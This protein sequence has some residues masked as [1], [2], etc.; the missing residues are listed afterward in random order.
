MKISKNSSDRRKRA[1]TVRARSGQLLRSGGNYITLVLTVMLCAAAAV[2][3]YFLTAMI[4]DITLSW[5]ADAI[6]LTLLLLIFAPMALGAVRVAISIYCG[7][8]N[9]IS[10]VFF[11][12]SSFD[13]YARAILLA[14]IQA[15]KLALCV[16]PSAIAVSALS[17]PMLSLFVRVPAVAYLLLAAVAVMLF[18]AMLALTAPLYGTLFFAFADGDVRP[19][20]GI[21]QSVRAMGFSKRTVGMRLSASAEVILSALPLC[22]PLLLYEIPY[23]LCR[24]VY[25]MAHACDPETKTERLAE[26]IEEKII[27]TGDIN[28]EQH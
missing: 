2:L 4:A 8:E 7:G 24:Y 5:V 1:V 18:G 9:P 13:V 10:E 12:F 21:V 17:E 14:L 25:Y 19:I 27:E 11:A 3:S 20:K 23:L 16:L 6:L 22:L 26:N 15:A 28:N